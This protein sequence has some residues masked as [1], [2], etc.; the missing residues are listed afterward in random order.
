MFILRP[1]GVAYLIDLIEHTTNIKDFM[2]CCAKKYPPKMSE[3]INNIL[4]P[5]AFRR[6]AMTHKILLD[7]ANLTPRMYPMG[8]QSVFSIPKIAIIFEQIESNP[9]KRPEL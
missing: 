5:N 7:D 3:A 4:P 8:I 9:T 6:S 1:E 2:R